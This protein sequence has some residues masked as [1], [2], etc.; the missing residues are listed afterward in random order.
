MITA[1]ASLF[2][3]L[4]GTHSITAT[5]IMSFCPFIGGQIAIPASVNEVWGESALNNI[6]AFLY[7]FIG[8]SLA[9][10]F[11]I[12]I[13]YYIV[14]YIKKT[15]F[16]EKLSDKLKSKNNNLDNEKSIYNK[17]LYLVFII[18]SIPLPFLGV[19]LSAFL[20]IW[21]GIKIKHLFPT[22]FVGNLISCII[23]TIICE[24]F[25]GY[26]SLIFSVLIPFGFIIL[27]LVLAKKFLIN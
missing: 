8:S 5:I 27:I 4:F 15:K 26:V 19:W 20:G 11:A 18:M 6:N 2:V 21:F 12:F 10:I 14:N 3:K 1:I 16:Y 22:L 17:H 24:I 13:F 23:C 9:I 7:S 25:K